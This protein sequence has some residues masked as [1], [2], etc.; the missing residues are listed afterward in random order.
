M[1]VYEVWLEE[2]KTSAKKFLAKGQELDSHAVLPVDKLATLHSTA[3]NAET[4][5]H[6]HFLRNHIPLTDL[7]ISRIPVI[8][9][10]D[11]IIAICH[12]KIDANWT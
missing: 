6:S 7:I 10:N 11:M 2:I 1:L 5:A 4:Q 9:N 3:P 8:I 12:R